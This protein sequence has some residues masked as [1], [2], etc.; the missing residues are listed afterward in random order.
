MCSLSD[1]KHIAKE[2]YSLHWRHVNLMISEI[3]GYPWIP[4]IKAGNA[5]PWCFLS[6]WTH[7]SINSRV[8]CDLRGHNPH[9]TSVWCLNIMMQNPKK[10]QQGNKLSHFRVPHHPNFEILPMWNQWIYYVP[11]HVWNIRVLFVIFA[12]NW[13][14]MVN[15]TWRKPSLDM[16]LVSYYLLLDK[17][18]QTLH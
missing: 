16:P 14:M 2:C 13:I 12:V 8:A 4:L 15:N 18:R 1:N 17:L 10:Y 6:D 11:S 3:T 5:K 7:T 9:V